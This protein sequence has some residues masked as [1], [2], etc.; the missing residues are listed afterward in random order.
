MSLVICSNAEDENSS[1]SNSI[2]EPWS[3]KNGLS[4]TYVIPK[5]AQVGLHSAKININATTTLSG[6]ESVYQYFGELID[7]DVAG[8]DNIN[9]STADPIRTT[10]GLTR[11]R[12]EDYDADG[13]ASLLTTQLNNWIFHP[14]LRTKV[15]VD[16]I[17]D[18]ATSTPD[19]YTIEYG[20]YNDESTT[21][22][23]VV[24]KVWDGDPTQLATIREVFDINRFD[25]PSGVLTTNYPADLPAPTAALNWNYSIVGA[26][27]VF[28]SLAHGTDA[29][30]I[31]EN[32][33][34]SGA[35]PLSLYNGE[36]EVNISNVNGSDLGWTVGLTRFC[37]EDPE[38]QNDFA[39]VYFDHTRGNPRAAFTGTFFDFAVIREGDN[40]YLQHTICDTDPTFDLE[41]SKDSTFVKDILYWTLDGSPF[42]GR[43]DISTAA[44]TLL[45]DRVRFKARGQ[46]MQVDLVD[47]TGGLH[48]LYTYAATHSK[49]N[50]LKPISQAC[51][52]LH[53]L[54]KMDTTST[55]FTNEMYIEKFKGCKDITNYST[56]W[57]DTSTIRDNPI[58]YSPYNSAG[59]W[60][61]MAQNGRQNEVQALE[62]RYWND[63]DDTTSGPLGNGQLNYAGLPTSGANRRIGHVDGTGALTTGFQNVFLPGPSTVYPSKG[64]MRHRLGFTESVVTTFTSSGVG[65]TDLGLIFTSDGLPKLTSGQSIFVRLD[66]FTQLTRN[67]FKSNNS[68]IIAHLPRFEGQDETNRLFYEP[69][70]IAWIDLN[71]AYEQSI[72]SFDI[73]FCYVNEQYVRALTGQSIVVL[74][75]RPK[76][77][78]SVM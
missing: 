39:P 65:A 11:G 68:G 5:N 28:K 33:M 25:Y 71:N 77:S 48:N 26:S 60:E 32:S 52:N 50:Q 40:I 67:A 23:P 72:S 2:Y 18:T 55:D 20:Q 35:L 47:T 59:W 78:K 64:N 38:D 57:G 6:N 70:E 31:G 21:T 1:I 43:Y 34:I 36:F 63:L 29:D 10:M 53:P 49:G 76:P 19:G 69:S 66:N 9:L 62:L 54:L 8:Q 4:S 27:G 74:M 24:E 17:R 13:I 14:N 22:L 15:D 7:P 45:I 61:Y 58:Q 12:F 46:Q 3:F 73:S 75:F 42:A 37:N 30:F 16:V 56:D 41:T 51:W 44:N